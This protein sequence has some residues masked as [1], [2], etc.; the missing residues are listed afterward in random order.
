MFLFKILKAIFE[1]FFSSE[2][3]IVETEQKAADPVEPKVKMTNDTVKGDFK[4]VTEKD[5]I[6][7]LAEPLK[8]F[9]KDFV[10]AGHKYG[11]DPR[12]LASISMLETGRGTSSAFKNKNNAMGISDVNGP[13]WCVSVAESI[14]RQSKS[15]TRPGG[16]YLKAKTIDEIGAIYSPPGAG[17]DVHGTNSSW[18]SLVSKFYD[19]FLGSDNR[20]QVRV[21]SAVP[22]LKRILKYGDTGE[23]VKYVQEILTREGAFVGA[24]LGNFLTLTKEAVQYFQNTHINEKGEFLEVDGRVGKETWWALHNPNGS[25]Q[26]SFV[27]TTEEAEVVGSS[28]R[29]RVLEFLKKHHASNVREIPNGSNYG[30]GVTA[31]VNACGFTYGIAWCMAEMSYAE[32][33]ANGEAPLG[34]MHVSC[35]QFWNKAMDEGKAHLKKSSYVPIPGDIAI[36]AYGTVGKDG[37]FY[38]NGHAVRVARVSE[39]G[40]KFNAYEG[41]AGNRLKYS[42][43]LTSEATLV[44]Y[45]NIYGDAANPPKFKRGI[46]E[47]PVVTL[48]LAE[49]R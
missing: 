9:A 42:V 19:E 8:P 15:L 46:T 40:K 49:S 45:V 21:I 14:D 48:T 23:D 44:G 4:H 10:A 39:D 6:P 5:L 30:D 32:K 11:I 20:K 43:R 2:K 12:F 16:Y 38:S 1:G 34:A 29:T 37:K 33:Q 31:V 13:I 17:N 36:Y 3:V 26:K 28:K 22:E 47:A 7:K 18:P 35:Y 24:C 27:D 25:A 41:N